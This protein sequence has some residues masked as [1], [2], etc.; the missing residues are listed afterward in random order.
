MLELIQWMKTEPENGE[1]T[2]EV[3]QVQVFTSKGAKYTW[4]SLKDWLCNC[5]KCVTI[6]S[7]PLFWLSK[8]QI[9]GRQFQ[10]WQ[11]VVG[12]NFHWRHSHTIRYESVARGTLYTQHSDRG[13]KYPL[14]Q[15]FLYQK[16]VNLF[17]WGT[18]ILQ[19]IFCEGGS[20]KIL[21]HGQSEHSTSQ[22]SGQAEGGVQQIF[23]RKK[24]Q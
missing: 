11:F 13:C 14:L 22:S 20:A 19:I 9:F 17:K 12:C 21:L 10:L 2:L 18:E 1:W 23:Y 8:L 4:K 15:T 7:I 6:P 3:R 16:Y 24:F 5:V